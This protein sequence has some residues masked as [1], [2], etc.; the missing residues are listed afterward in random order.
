[1]GILKRL[2]AVLVWLLATV[3]TV[4]AV[5]LCVTLIL[6]PLGVPLM[7]VAIRM[8]GLGVKLMLPSLPDASD[9]GGSAKRSWHRLGKKAR[10]STPVQKL[11]RSPWQKLRKRLA[12]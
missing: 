8:Y 3:L 7:G 11:H 4:V 12:P 1:M 6:L 9:V 10:T 5:I 2:A